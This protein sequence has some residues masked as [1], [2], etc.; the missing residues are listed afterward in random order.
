MHPIEQYLKKNARQSISR[1]CST[2]SHWSLS[3]FLPE[4]EPHSN[5]YCTTLYALHDNAGCITIHVPPHCLKN[6][7]PCLNMD[8]Y[9][10]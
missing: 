2:G 1:T 4:P 3:E 10:K 6:Y 7:M 5:K 8:F 9:P